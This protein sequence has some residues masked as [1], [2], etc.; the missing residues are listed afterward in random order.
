MTGG[1]YKNLFYWR[2]MGDLSGGNP[3]YEVGD[4]NKHFLLW[5]WGI[6]AAIRNHAFVLIGPQGR[7][8]ISKGNFLVIGD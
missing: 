4:G 6:S 1:T 3:L 8:I 2:L 5:K 7:Q